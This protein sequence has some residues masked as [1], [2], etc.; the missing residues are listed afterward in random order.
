[1]RE[2]IDN[3][4]QLSEEIETKIKTRYNTLESWSNKEKDYSKANEEAKKVWENL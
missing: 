3:E 4:R 2:A 1:L